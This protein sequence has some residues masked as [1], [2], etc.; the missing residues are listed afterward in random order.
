[1]P[2]GVRQMLGEKLQVTGRCH[3]LRVCCGCMKYDG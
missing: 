1:M 2:N 3:V